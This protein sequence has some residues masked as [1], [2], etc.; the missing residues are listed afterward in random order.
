MSCPSSHEGNQGPTAE[1]ASPPLVSILAHKKRLVD[2]LPPLHRQA[3]DVTDGNRSLLFV[4]N[5]RDGSLQAMSGFGLDASPTDPWAPAADE[6]AIVAVAFARGTPLV[7]TDADR[8][9]PDLASRLGARAAVLL[10]LASGNE[11]IG[12]V[13]IGF[14]NRAP[15]SLGDDVPAVADAFLPAIEIARLRQRDE[16]QRDLRLLLDEFTRS[17][18]G[19][20]QLAVGLDVFC[21]GTNRLFG[22]DRTS[23]WIHDR[24]A[25]RLF[26]R[27]S[28]APEPAAL[29]VHI[30]ANDPSSPAAAA[31]WRSRAEILEPN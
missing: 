24:R 26:L 20:L 25:S 1:A 6:R 19:T 28:T 5:P 2:L 4:H 3:L 9:M 15:A 11:R 17:L 8:D 31:M 23:V 14:S 7:I 27:A 18:S 13:T 29:D 16:L 22:A 12:M 21:H 30:A 10:P